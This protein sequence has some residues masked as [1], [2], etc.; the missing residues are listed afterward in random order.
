MRVI[1]M[2]AFKGGSGKSTMTINLAATLAGS[3][4]VAVI[5]LD[6]QGNA[7]GALPITDI[8]NLTA[9]EALSEAIRNPK[10]RLRPTDWST[11]TFDDGSG[12]YLL[13]TPD[14]DALAQV[15][16]QLSRPGGERTLQ[17]LISSVRGLDAIL[18]DTAPSLSWLISNATVASTTVFSVFTEQRWS[19]EGAI[20]AENLVQDMRAS[21]ISKATFGGAILNKTKARQSV[22]AKVVQELST[23]SGLKVLKTTIP[24]RAA[25]YEGELTSLPVVIA[26]PRS[27]ITKSFNDLGREVWRI[28]KG[29]T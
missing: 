10:F 1:S 25:V 12:F 17:R 11:V 9:A 22:S 19:L 20:K 8:G 29:R 18:I 28:S 2:V 7:S 6:P 4:A 15:A 16:E 23:D 24:E 26:S 27:A 14:P 5:D 21:K 3:H 13:P